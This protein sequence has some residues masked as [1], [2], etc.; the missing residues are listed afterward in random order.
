ME[1]GGGGGG[2]AMKSQLMDLIN[3]Q[4]KKGPVKIIVSTY[5]QENLLTRVA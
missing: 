3:Y 4:K 5:F 1:G 2:G